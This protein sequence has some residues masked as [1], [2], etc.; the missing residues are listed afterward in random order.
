[1]NIIF[2]E[3]ALSELYE[4]GKTKNKK[5]KQI[6]KNKR[7]VDGNFRAVG[8][9]YDVECTDELKNFSFSYAMRN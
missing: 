9:I 7:L 4:I 6:C 3:E 2:K 5:Y 1:M 8:N